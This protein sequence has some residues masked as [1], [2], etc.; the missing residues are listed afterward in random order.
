MI[1]F[2]LHHSPD[3]QYKV[4]LFAFLPAT[5]MLAKSDIALFWMM[6]PWDKIVTRN[7]PQKEHFPPILQLTLYLSLSFNLSRFSPALLN[8]PAAHTE[9][10]KFLGQGSTVPG[11]GPMAGGTAAQCW[12]FWVVPRPENLSCSRLLTDLFW[13][14]L[15]VVKWTTAEDFWFGF[16]GHGV[17]LQCST[18]RS[19]TLLRC[20]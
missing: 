4:L 6:T 2:V 19:E 12:Q 17:P 14:C 20:S 1:F 15:K 5:L 13:P 10:V 8:G 3:Q 7:N 16:E 11:D 9:G 18:A